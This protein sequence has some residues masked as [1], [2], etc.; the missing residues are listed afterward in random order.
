MKEK[1]Q[2]IVK[3]FD[4]QDTYNKGLLIFAFINIVG[5]LIGTVC[6]IL[7]DNMIYDAT[8]LLTTLLS[9]MNLACLILL[10]ISVLSIIFI[11]L[12]TCFNDNNKDKVS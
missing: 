12:H 5:F 9:F 4:K 7:K 10:V 2:D 6:V 11:L 3:W 1:L 8:L